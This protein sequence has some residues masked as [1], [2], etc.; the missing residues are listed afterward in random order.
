MKNAKYLIMTKNKSGAVSS[1][2]LSD[3]EG[4][5]TGK[6][7]M[8]TPE[9][10][11]E[12]GWFKFMMK[13]LIGQEFIITQPVESET[14]TIEARHHAIWSANMKNFSKESYF[15]D[16]QSKIIPTIMDKMDIENGIVDMIGDTGTVKIENARDYLTPLHTI[17]DEYPNFINFCEKNGFR[18]MLLLVQHVDRT[19][20]YFAEY[21]VASLDVPSGELRVT[22]NPVEF[23][24][25]LVPGKYLFCGELFSSNCMN[26]KSTVT[27][28]FRETIMSK[29]SEK[30]E[31]MN[32]ISDTKMK[33]IS[34]AFL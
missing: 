2:F 4:N 27:E 32:V 5:P 33:A 16:M 31:E 21:A 28:Q 14:D 18:T 1:M 3:P 20:K 12:H 25:S 34:R 23:T 13:E 19:K 9:P 10:T 26:A 22:F 11:G 7:R 30:I 24:E 15:E 29:I 6:L 8:S 17:P